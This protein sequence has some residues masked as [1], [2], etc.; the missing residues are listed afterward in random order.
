[1]IPNKFVYKLMFV[2]LYDF[3]NR[4]K[5]MVYIFLLYLFLFLFNNVKDGSILIIFISFYFLLFAENLF[6]NNSFKRSF[7]RYRK[8]LRLKRK[9]STNTKN[10]DLKWTEK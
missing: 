4:G 7:D 2:F 1:M 5:I 8:Y 3:A 6:I 10:K 9:R